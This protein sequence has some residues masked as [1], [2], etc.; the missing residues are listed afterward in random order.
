M[1]PRMV[2]CIT[3]ALLEYMQHRSTHRTES[4]NAE[5]HMVWSKASIQ[6][7][8]LSRYIQSPP[9][10]HQSTH[11]MNGQVHGPKNMT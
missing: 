6:S 10:V 11:P 4:L 1:L 2:Q 7:N 8:S 3:K 5:I 9:F